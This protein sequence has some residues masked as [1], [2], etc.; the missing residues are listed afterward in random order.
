MADRASARPARKPTQRNHLMNAWEGMHKV[1][2]NRGGW[3][4]V[5]HIVSQD[6]KVEKVARPE[7]RKNIHLGS[8]LDGT[9]GGVHQRTFVVV[10]RVGPRMQCRN[11]RETGRRLGGLRE[12]FVAFQADGD[13]NL[14]FT[15]RR[16][17]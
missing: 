6:G 16:I 9:R 14:R 17:Q 3:P 10:S 11:A 15:L 13:A 4:L 12:I 5:P 8:S 1:E 2:Q 7:T